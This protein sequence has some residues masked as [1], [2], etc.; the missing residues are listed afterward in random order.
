MWVG[1]WSLTRPLV[2]L[3]TAT[4]PSLPE[5]KAADYVIS[6]LIAISFPIVR[7]CL[8]KTLYHVS[9]IPASLAS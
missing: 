7:Y 8:D 9:Y 2:L 1:G 3:L 4:F 6:S 5:E